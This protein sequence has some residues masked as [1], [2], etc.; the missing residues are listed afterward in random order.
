MESPEELAALGP[1]WEDTPAVFY[2]NETKSERVAAPVEPVAETVTTEP[3]RRGRGR[4]R[5]NSVPGEPGPET[6]TEGEPETE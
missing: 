5:K 2:A 1:G 6:E 3:Q 4:P